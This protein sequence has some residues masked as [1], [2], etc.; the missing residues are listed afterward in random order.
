MKL[1]QQSPFYWRGGINYVPF[2]SCICGISLLQEYGFPNIRQHIKEV[3]VKI[4][5]L[6]FSK[7]KTLYTVFF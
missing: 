4:G 7:Q 6:N 5:K 2:I 3:K 1:N